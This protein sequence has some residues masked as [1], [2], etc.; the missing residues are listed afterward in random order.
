MLI[1][2][3]GTRGEIQS[4]SP[5]HSL[6][7]GILIDKKI[8]FD[9]GEEAFLK[10]RPK[11]V[12]ITH[13]H[14]DHAFFIRHNVPILKTKIE[15]FAPEKTTACANIKNLRKKKRIGNYEIIPIPTHHSLKVVSQAYIIKKGKTKILYTGDMIWIDKKYHRLLKN[16]QLVITEASYYR[17]GGLIIKDLKTGKLYGHTGIPDLMKLFSQF[18]NNILFVH[19]GSWFYKNEKNSIKRLNSLAKQFKINAHIGY[20]GV[21]INTS[22]LK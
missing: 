7:S 18:T 21:S 20:D 12:F 10:F 13:L 22:E 17:K 5:L 9:L 6:H 19:F 11:A 16:L 1:K 15:I 14:P 8:M 2:V 4:F 3:L